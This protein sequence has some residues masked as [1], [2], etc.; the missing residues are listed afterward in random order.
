MKPVKKTDL[1]S[2]EV[3]LSKPVKTPDGLLAR[4]IPVG[5]QRDWGTG[6]VVH[7]A[8]EHPR[9]ILC[10]LEGRIKMRRFD[11]EGREQIQTW[12]TAGRV[13]A[14]PYVISNVPLHFDIVAEGPCK[15]LHVDRP[16]LLELLRKD[17]A[18]S[19]AIIDL[20]SERQIFLTESYAMHTK[21]ALADRLWHRLTR[22]ANQQTGGSVLSK[23]GIQI[24]QKELADAV[25][26]SRY[27]VGI[28]LQK[29][30]DR[31]TIVMSRGRIQLIDDGPSET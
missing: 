14:L 29:M 24:T 6:Q 5:T 20:L 15:V 7:W 3:A 10:V 18:V 17:S 26:A 25:G 13:A 11:S 27:R 28:E 9:A 22:M 8:G 2:R 30:V 23:T 21:E 19:M 16:E 1:S 4:L 12:F 31:G